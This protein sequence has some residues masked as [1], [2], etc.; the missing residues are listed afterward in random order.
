[1]TNIQAQPDRL[2]LLKWLINTEKESV[3]QWLAELREKDIEISNDE[4]LNSDEVQ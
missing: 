4:S 1:M 2:M 3:W